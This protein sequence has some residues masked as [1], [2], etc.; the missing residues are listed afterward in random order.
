MPI[1][2]PSPP[3]P[4]EPPAA[5]GGIPPAATGCVALGCVGAS[6]LVGV[7]SEGSAVGSLGAVGVG[8]GATVAFGSVDVG[9]ALVVG[10]LPVELELVDDE[11]LV[12]LDVVGSVSGAGLELSSPQAQT[13]L[14]VTSAPPQAHVLRA[15]PRCPGTPSAPR[16]SV[17][18][19]VV[20]R[21]ALVVC[22]S[23]P[24]AQG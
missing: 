10:V 18:G 5:T 19:P 2:P 4:A 6:G 11:E 12:V 14:A 15:R 7:G 13:T 1:A 24:D 17:M 21:A 3:A 8:I 16:P 23:A 22:S 9:L 20:E